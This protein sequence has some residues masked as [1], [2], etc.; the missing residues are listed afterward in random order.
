MSFNAAMTWTTS[1]FKERSLVLNDGNQ[2]PELRLLSYSGLL[3]STID[4]PDQE[5][6]PMTIKVDTPSTTT[7]YIGLSFKAGP[8]Q[9]TQ[10]NGNKVTIHSVVNIGSTR[11]DSLFRTA[12]GSGETYTIENHDKAG[13]SLHVLVHG[14]DTPSRLAKVEVRIESEVTNPPSTSLVPISS[15]AMRATYTEATLEG[16]CDGDLVQKSY[17][18]ALYSAVSIGS[19]VQVERATPACANTGRDLQNSLA[20]VLDRTIL[21][22]RI[23]QYETKPQPERF[24]FRT[25]V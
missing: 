10:A 20:R 8:N 9:G 23:T 11:A 18:D 13:S 22:A 16:S 3:S 12:L 4:D 24:T 25:S 14:I 6:P 19:A 17:V 15:P 7:F 1:W 2:S 21:V 5:G